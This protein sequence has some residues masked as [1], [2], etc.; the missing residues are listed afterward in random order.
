M[1]TRRGVF[2]FRIN[3]RIEMKTK[4]WNHANN[5]SKSKYILGDW[6]EEAGVVRLY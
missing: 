5:P 6:G 3:G 2:Q 1:K 4:T